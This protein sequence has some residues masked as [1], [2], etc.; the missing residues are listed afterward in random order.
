MSEELSDADQE[1][2]AYKVT[3]KLFWWTVAGVIAFSAIM[4]VLANF[5]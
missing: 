5:F 2:Y 3:R 4:V 1:Q